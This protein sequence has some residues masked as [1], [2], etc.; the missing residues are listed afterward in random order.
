MPLAE[1]LEAIRTEVTHL[2]EEAYQCLREQ[3]LPALRK[4]ASG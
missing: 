2:M 1:Q 4:P 3:L